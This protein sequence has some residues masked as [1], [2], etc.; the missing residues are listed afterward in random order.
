MSTP[1]DALTCAIELA[2]WPLSLVRA[3]FESMAVV[4]QSLLV[5][6]ASRFGDGKPII[7]VP[8]FFGTDF[9]L[10][11][12][13]SW[14][15]AL[16][17]R[18]VT[19][20]PPSDSSLSRVI[21][22]VTRRVGRKAVLITHCFGMTQALSAADLHREQISDVVV[23]G[24]ARSLDTASVRTHFVSAWSTLHAM[25]ELRQLLRG[26]DLEL[27]ENSDFGNSDSSLATGSAQTRGVESIGGSECAD[28]R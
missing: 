15:K 8:Q 16:G 7:L 13:A 5:G 27:I 12:F 22:D 17:Y 3:G 19:A 28:G 6:S 9:A 21:H 26:I 10:F 4:R 24:A 11:P 1:S 18:T 23:L 2:I 14:L 25:T 20:A